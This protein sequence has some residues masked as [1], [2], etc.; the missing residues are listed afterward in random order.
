M[1]NVTN[2]VAK[3]DWTFVDYL[4]FINA[5][6]EKTIENGIEYKNFY[7]ALFAANMFYDYEPE[8]DESG[9]FNL[10]D[11]WNDL[12]HFKGI[13]D[14]DGNDI[15]EDENGID[16]YFVFENLD[17]ISEADNADAFV[18]KIIPIDFYIFKEMVDTINTKVDHWNNRDTVK[19]AVTNLMNKISDYV[20]NMESKFDGV[21]IEETAKRVEKYADAIKNNDFKQTAREL[22]KVIHAENQDAANRRLNDNISGIDLKGKLAV[23]NPNYK[24]E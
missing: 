10:N 24:K 8:T 13:K 1:K 3:K 21:D 11:V 4:T 19:E 6:V 9:N 20:D 5:V 15:V 14:E 16:I 12:R 18:K 7:L 23:E 22:A 2:N 17:M